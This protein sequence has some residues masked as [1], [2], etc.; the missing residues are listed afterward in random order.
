MKSKL[1]LLISSKRISF[2]GETF[3]GSLTLFSCRIESLH[4]VL[5]ADWK[6]YDGTNWQIGFFRNYVEF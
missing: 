1:K 2:T 3:Q 5:R 4:I 6:G